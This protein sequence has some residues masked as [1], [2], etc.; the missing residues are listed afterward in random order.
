MMQHRI[1]RRYQDG[2]VKHGDWSDADEATARRLAEEG[3][4]CGSRIVYWVES[5]PAPRPAPVDGA[6]LVDAII[7]ERRA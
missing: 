6:A 5:R 3:N 1:V 7:R 2:A 4:A